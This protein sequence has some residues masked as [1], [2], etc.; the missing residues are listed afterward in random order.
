MFDL[1][2][3]QL[4]NPETTIR[5]QAIIS[6]ANLADPR[7]LPVL[8]DVHRKDADPA[9]RDLALKAR[10]HIEA[11]I[12]GSDSSSLS[13]PKLPASFMPIADLRSA[14]YPTT[15]AVSER[16]KKEA[17]RQLDS[18]IDSFTRGNSQ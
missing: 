2:I 3:R 18:A 11:R 8:E 9:V 15:R 1:C 12:Q 4:D 5:R 16:D 10:Q 6:L 13:S 14:S 17:K 7:A